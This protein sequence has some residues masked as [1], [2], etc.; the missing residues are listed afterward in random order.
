MKDT[1]FR[2]WWGPFLA[3]WVFLI[4]LLTGCVPKAGEGDVPKISTADTAARLEESGVLILDVR[5][6]AQYIASPRKIRGAVYR[7]PQTVDQ[8]AADLPEGK[9]LVLYCA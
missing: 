6:R 4:V 5:P 1:R 7:D 3:G 9:T 2:R 8:W